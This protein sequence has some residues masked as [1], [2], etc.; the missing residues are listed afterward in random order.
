MENLWLWSRSQE[1]KSR[2]LQHNASLQAE[3]K[4]R[5]QVCFEVDKELGDEP[6]LPM[7]NTLFLAEGA[8]PE[9]SSAPSLPAQLPTP[10]KSSQQSHALTKGAQPK[11]PAAPSHG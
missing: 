9:G 5:K 2:T 4:L 7:D 11:V 8:A 3:K 6:N 1:P 10:I